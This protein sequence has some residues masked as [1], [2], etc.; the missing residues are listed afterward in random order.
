MGYKEYISKKYD[1]VKKNPIASAWIGFFK[2]VLYT[3]LVYEFLL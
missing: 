2:G 1:W 3:V